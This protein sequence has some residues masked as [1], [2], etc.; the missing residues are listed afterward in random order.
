MLKRY[1]R[2]QVG[3][4]NEDYIT[5]EVDHANGDPSAYVVPHMSIRDAEDLIY[6]LGKAI[7]EIRAVF[8][9]RFGR[10]L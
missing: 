4:Y 2:F 10:K 9:I 5:L 1:G 7:E 6:A 8:E 3:I